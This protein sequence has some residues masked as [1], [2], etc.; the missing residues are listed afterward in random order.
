MGNVGLEVEDAGLE[1]PEIV[2]Q[3]GAIRPGLWHHA[4]VVAREVGVRPQRVA[5]LP[6]QLDHVALAVGEVIFR[7]RP[8]AVELPV[9]PI[10]HEQTELVA[11]VF[12]V[13]GVLRSPLLE[14]AHEARQVGGA[15][16]ADFVDDDL[17]LR[18][19]EFAER[20]H[21]RDFGD[22]VRHSLIGMDEGLDRGA[23]VEHQSVFAAEGQ[24]RSVGLLAAHEALPLH[25]S[26]IGNRTLIEL[27]VEAAA[28]EK[29]KTRVVQVLDQRQ[30]IDRA[31][32]LLARP[33]FIEQAPA[34]HARVVAIAA[35]HRGHRVEEPF[36]ELRRVLNL[37][38]AVVL[39]QQENPQLVEEI[40][41]P[42][43]KA[44][45]Q[46]AD[47]VQPHELQRSHVAA[48]EIL[49]RHDAVADRIGGQEQ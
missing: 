14:V 17:A 36:L 27:H 11:V 3:S 46:A 26:R 40:D 12:G 10:G 24:H 16:R 19:G 21:P 41:I 15:A 23:V 8:D 31:I 43:A 28:V 38:A 7:A 22:R 45:P 42:G 32:K 1:F 35:D 25:R 4:E 39:L 44:A 18:R 34:D 20:A 13:G 47:G 49:A 30:G 9:F 29:D 33:H 37:D 5:C 48:Q 2:Q 6:A